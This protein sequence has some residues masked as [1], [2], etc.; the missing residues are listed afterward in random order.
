MSEP[1]QEPV[2]RHYCIEGR[3]QGVGFRW[4]VHQEAS[5]LGLRGWVRNTP[6][7]TVEVTAAGSTDAL[8]KLREALERGPRGSRVDRIVED[9]LAPAEAANLPA[10]TIQGAI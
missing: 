3:V 1:T 2:V 10:F 4:F 9:A 7:N 6:G 5:A 8:K